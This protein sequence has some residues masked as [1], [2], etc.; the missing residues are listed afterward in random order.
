MKTTKSPKNHS[1]CH[2]HEAAPKHASDPSAKEMIDGLIY[3]CPMHLE[4]RQTN[5]G[6]CPICGMALEPEKST[7]ETGQTPEYI[8][9]KNRF[10]L[11]LVMT[12]PIVTLAM[13]EHI[14]KEV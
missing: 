3:T 6:N 10:W 13:S 4:I 12:I 11:A 14:Q 1:C 7:I 9:M 5:P 2:Q 8:D